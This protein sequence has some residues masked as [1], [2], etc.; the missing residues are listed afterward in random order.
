MKNLDLEKAYL[1]HLANIRNDLFNRG[2]LEKS[3]LV[4]KEIN[5]IHRRRV[6]K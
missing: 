3:D 4:Q 5:E 1:K 2:F 6:L